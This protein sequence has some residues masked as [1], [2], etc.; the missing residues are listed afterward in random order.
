MFSKYFYSCV[1]KSYSFHYSFTI[2]YSCIFFSSP[3]FYSLV[4]IRLD[5]KASPCDPLN[6]LLSITSTTQ[7]IDQTF[8]HPYWPSWW[9]NS[10][11]VITYWISLVR[12]WPECFG[13]LMSWKRGSN[14][15]PPT[16]VATRGPRP[17][18]HTGGKTA[19]SGRVPMLASVSASQLL[20]LLACCCPCQVNP[21]LQV[22]I[23][24]SFEDFGYHPWS[25]TSG[26]YTYNQRLLIR[27]LDFWAASSMMRGWKETRTCKQLCWRAE[28]YLSY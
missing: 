9:P 22:S 21:L 24:I 8:S 4:P 17:G 15:D 5:F 27:P 11:W 19:A 16:A 13:L 26:G 10:V 3:I 7:W 20:W 14:P 12:F 1:L 25:D 2:S 6:L 28:P 18:P 23:Q